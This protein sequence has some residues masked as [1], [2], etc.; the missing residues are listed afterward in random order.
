M[1]ANEESKKAYTVQSAAKVY[2]VSTDTIRAALK[3][4]DLNAKYPT[5]RPV[6]GAKELDNWFN[7]L[8]DEPRP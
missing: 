3:R 4:G 2:D 8:A 1:S 6:I 5:S 7:S